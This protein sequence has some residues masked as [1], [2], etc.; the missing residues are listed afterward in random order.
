MRIAFV[1]TLYPPHGASGAETTL[2]FLARE[3]A[4]RGH[5]C[6]VVTLTPA[7]AESAGEV[8]GVPVR[9]LP[10][11]NV[12]WPHGG[13]RP[14]A[15]RP[16]FQGLDAWNPVM[17]RRLAAAL[18]ALR[19]DVVHAHNLQ[20]FSVAAW[21]AAS[22][23]RIPLV[24]TLHDYYTACPRSAMWRPGRGNCARPCREC[25]AF[26]AP[27]R[28]LSSLP[29]VVT[30]VSHR[31]VDRIVAAGTFAGAGAGRP[32]VRIIRGNNPDA[33]LPPLPDGRGGG[34]WRFGFMGRLDAAKGLELLLD[35]F[36]GLPD[37]AATLTVAGTGD[38]AYTAALQA[39]AAGR[40]GITFAG[41]VAPASF[42]SGIDLLVIPSV[43]EDPFPRV[44]HEALAFG[45]PTLV[46]PLGG[47]PEAIEHGRTGLIAAAATAGTLRDGME[48]LMAGAWDFEA[49]RSRCR[50]AAADYAP[51]KIVSEYEAAL[52]AAAGLGA[53]DGAG[54]AWRPATEAR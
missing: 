14:A 54:A 6:A 29:A 1:N 22:R 3:L 21:R 44:F 20:G 23:L 34:P 18:R 24:Q 31:L 38:P 52:A 35:A 42:F 40:N 5:D 37:G 41:H 13:R 16:V 15:L 39:L 27:R 32:P 17:G 53:L 48:R 2:R 46:T 11:A 28:A 12:Y 33:A 43:W 30:A 26:S 19:P 36:A 49:M 50:I 9:Y 10:L 25:R 7:R 51:A 47:L 8:D 45:V 4:G